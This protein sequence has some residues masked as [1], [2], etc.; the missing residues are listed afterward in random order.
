MTIFDF[1]SKHWFITIL[2]VCIL[3]SFI[4]NALVIINNAIQHKNNKLR[5][6]FEKIKVFNRGEESENDN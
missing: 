3:G 2:S 4:H 5:L 6:E 1:I